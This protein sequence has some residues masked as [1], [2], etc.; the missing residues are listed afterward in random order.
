MVHITPPT[1]IGFFVGDHAAHEEHLE[2][3][4]PSQRDVAVEGFEIDAV[5][6]DAD[7]VAKLRR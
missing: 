6:N 2:W 4:G 3:S 1:G 7:A 5:S